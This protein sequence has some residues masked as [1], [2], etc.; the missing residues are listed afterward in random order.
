MTFV[1]GEYFLGE[2]EFVPE[3]FP[4]GGTCPRNV[5]GVVRGEYF[6]EGG[7]ICPGD[8]VRGGKCRGVCSGRVFSERGICPGETVRGGK[9]PR[10]V[11]GVVR[12]EYFPE[13]GE[14]CPGEIV[15][16]VKCPRNVGVCSGKVFSGGIVR[17]GN[18]REMLWGLIVESIFR[19]VGKNLSWRNCPGCD[20]PEKCGGLFGKSIF[21]GRDCP[22]GKC[23]GW[24]AR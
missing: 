3:K 24:Q 14:I 8:I 19:G 9:C 7:E 16:G 10:N 20:M 21:R 23:P 18:V 13:D 11:V 15:R 22:G 5:V 12:R 4:R 6:P 2:G 17:V 1:R